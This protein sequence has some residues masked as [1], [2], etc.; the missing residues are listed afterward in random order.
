VPSTSQLVVA[1]WY[2]LAAIVYIVIGVVFTDFLFSFWVGVGYLFVVAWCIPTA[3]RR[4][5]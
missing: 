5:L 1:A 2:A 3:V 4:F